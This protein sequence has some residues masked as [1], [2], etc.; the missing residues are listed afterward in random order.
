MSK[1]S[2][3]IKGRKARRKVPFPGIIDSTPGAPE[4]VLDLQVLD[5]EQEAEALARARA[6]AVGKGV[7]AP[8]SGEP[9]YDLG[10]MVHTLLLAAIDHDSPDEAPAPFFASSEEILRHLDRERIAYLYTLQQL[11]QE[12]LSPTSSKNFSEDRIFEIAI[13]A[14]DEEDP[15]RFFE[16]LPPATLARCLVFTARRLRDVLRLKSLSS[17]SFETAGSSEPKRSE[18]S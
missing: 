17:S 12:D 18:A 2:D 3:I 4:V 5:G 1:L 13:E 15:L 14:A 8:K 11:W 16:K 9:E 6:F 10:L 7:S